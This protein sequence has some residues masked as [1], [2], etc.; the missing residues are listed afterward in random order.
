MQLC[1]VGI[2]GMDPV[3]FWDFTFAEVEMMFH[4]HALKND[5]NANWPSIGPKRSAV[6]MQADF[7]ALKAEFAEARRK[8]GG[9]RA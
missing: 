2:L 6:D 7:D 4:A 9:E 8:K 3:S 1:A 5:P